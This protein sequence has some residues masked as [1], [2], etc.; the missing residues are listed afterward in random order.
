MNKGNYLSVTDP[1]TLAA[2]DYAVISEIPVHDQASFH[3]D[4][5][6]LSIEL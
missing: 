3:F 4:N 6:F 2:R 1:V 5:V